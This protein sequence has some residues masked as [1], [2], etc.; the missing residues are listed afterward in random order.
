MTRSYE[1]KGRT[2][3]RG[4]RYRAHK[5]SKPSARPVSARRQLERGMRWCQRAGDERVRRD[6]FNEGERLFL[7]IWQKQDAVMAQPNSREELTNCFHE[8][9]PSHRNSHD[10]APKR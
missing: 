7:S 3:I 5:N 2:G 8:A 9:V 1:S 4:D 10:R 6:M